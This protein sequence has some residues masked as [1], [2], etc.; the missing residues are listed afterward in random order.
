MSF[1]RIYRIY[2]F[3]LIRVINF[4]IILYKL[5]IKKFLRIKK[6]YCDTEKVKVINT[7]FKMNYFKKTFYKIHQLDLLSTCLNLLYLLVYRYT[8]FNTY[9]V[10]IAF[11][12]ICITHNDISQP[13]QNI[14]DKHGFCTYTLNLYNYSLLRWLFLLLLFKSQSS[15]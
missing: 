12:Q 1:Y 14:Y 10:N 11:F 9:L 15:V 6:M 13:T 4:R 2:R 3:Y 8:F 5:F 7:V